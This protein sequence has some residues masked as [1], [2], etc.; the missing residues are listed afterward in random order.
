M[1]MSTTLSDSPLSETPAPAQSKRQLPLFLRNKKT[2]VGV[3][4]LGFFVL[5]AIFGPLLAPYS[6][7]AESTAKGMSVAAPS[8]S[9]LLGTDQLGRDV[10]SQ[11]LIGTR[12][13]MLIGVVTGVIA[14]FLA[15]VV[16]VSAGYLGAKWDEFLSLLSN[17]FL[18]FPA[19]PF[20]IVV[21]GA[22]P[23]TGQVPI[24]AMLSLLGWP[25]GARVIRA[26]TLSLRNKDFV[27]AAQETGES[28][29]KI[30]FYDIV[31]NQI[32]LIAASFVSAVLYAIGASVGL[33]F[34]GIGNTST[35]SLGTILYWAQNGNALELGAWWWFAIP[36]VLIALIGTGLVLVNFGLDELGNPRLRDSGAVSRIN[37]RLWSPSDPTAVQAL[38]K[39]GGRSWR[40]RGHDTLVPRTDEISNSS[41]SGDGTNSVSFESLQRV[42][43]H[44]RSGSALVNAVDVHQSGGLNGQVHGAST[45]SNILEIRDLS[46]AYRSGTGDLKAV[47]NVNLAIR[48]AEIIGLAGES[49]SGKSTLAYGTCRLLR[50]PAVITSGSAIYRGS[51]RGASELDLMKVSA[52]DLDRLRWR[53]I[54]IVFQSAMN[55]LNPVLRIEDQLLD[56]IE[57]HLDLSRDEA[58]DRINEVIDLVNIPRN[59]LRSYPHELSG[60]MRQRVM[61]AMALTVN[62]RLIIMDEPTTALDVVVQR[63]ILAQISELKDRLGFS[64][65]FITHDLSLLV[66]LADRLA[67]M[68]A[69]SLM[70]I[71]E[72]SDV[73]A[74]IGH[75]YTEGL[76]NSF[77]PLHGPR[78]S[79]AGIPGTPPD[80][81]DA[82]QG[83][84]FVPRCRYSDDAC[85]KIHPTLL[86]LDCGHGLGHMS[87]CPFPERIRGTATDVGVV[88][89][90]T[91]SRDRGSYDSV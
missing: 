32:S 72:T 70:E 10:L 22:F 83:C 79:L 2:L 15:V 78:R 65:L 50:P 23:G 80:L 44:D 3:V 52:G 62:P 5:V 47:N 38:V 61:I 29:W 84:P 39:T 88:G 63:D 90:M 9:H 17:L 20:L 86:T 43:G 66:E 60:G 12:T 40:R 54:S 57:R 41:L 37:G 6:P 7:S 27:A 76:L 13:T 81:R 33:D 18:V 74:R 4:I 73:V 55:A 91:A 35:W 67:I 8:L 1:M 21:L 49:G 58:R 24:I 87:A 19:L 64:V 56:P 89:D 45:D 77:P 48:Q 75:P 25:W 69:G 14:T 31:P 30:I 28:S 59:R 26:Q 42:D 53:E 11:V 46:I 51:R 68:Y 82:V 34:L 16:G 36:G 85:T 71:G